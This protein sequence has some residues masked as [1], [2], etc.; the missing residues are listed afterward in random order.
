M[1]FLVPLCALVLLLPLSLRVAHADAPKW[2]EDGEMKNAL[3][4][5]R[6]Q[7]K[8]LLVHVYDGE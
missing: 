4:K 2:L 7:N 5:A 3:A 8:P 6:E 1:R